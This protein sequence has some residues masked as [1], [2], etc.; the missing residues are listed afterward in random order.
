[1]AVMT[2]AE[3]LAIADPALMLAFVEKKFSKR[4]LRLFAC[5]CCFRMWDEKPESLPFRAITYGEHWAEK[6]VFNGP[7]GQ[8]IWDAIMQ[9]QEEDMHAGNHLRAIKLLYCLTCL[10]EDPLFLFRRRT[11]ASIWGRLIQLPRRIFRLSSR[12]QPIRDD[13]DDPRTALMESWPPII[14]CIFGN[15]FRPVTFEAEWRTTTAVQIAKGMYDSRDFAAMPILADALQD[16]GCESATILDHC[17]GGGPHVRGCWVVDLV[18][19]KE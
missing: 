9:F 10:G 1:M 19:G 17:R 15:P 6:G 3:W 5:G 12:P 2:E 8:A 13:P 11:S 16:G 18:L 7:E 14:R 4:K